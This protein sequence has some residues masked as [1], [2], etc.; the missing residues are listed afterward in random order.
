MAPSVNGVK[1]DIFP[2]DFSYDAALFCAL[3]TAGLAIILGGVSRG[4]LL[5]SRRRA[6][7]RTVREGTVSFL[8]VSGL[9]ITFSS[10]TELPLRPVKNSKSDSSAHLVYLLAPSRSTHNA[11]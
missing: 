5:F 7:S 3:V 6:A 4:Y 10:F 11:L 8:S 1:H 9:L 2:P